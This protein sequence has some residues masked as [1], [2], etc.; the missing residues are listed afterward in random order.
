MLPRSSLIAAGP[1]PNF[2]GGTGRREPPP[3]LA[4][5]LSPKL[6]P[7]EY[8]RRN[9]TRRHRVVT[10]QGGAY[11]RGMASSRG[12]GRRGTSRLADMS[13]PADQRCARKTTRTSR[14]PV[15]AQMDHGSSPAGRRRRRDGERKMRQAR[16][17]PR[18][19]FPP[20]PRPGPGL[21]APGILG[22]DVRGTPLAGSPPDQPPARAPRAF[23]ERPG[24]HGPADLA[25]APARAV[26]DAGVQPQRRA[27]GGGQPEGGQDQAGDAPGGEGEQ[28]DPG[29]D[30]GEPRP[31]HRYPASRSLNISASAGRSWARCRSQFPS[32]AAAVSAS[33]SGPARNFRCRSPCRSTSTTRGTGTSAAPCGGALPTAAGSAEVTGAASGHVS[34]T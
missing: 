33:P 5:M 25:G 16:R 31:A 10:R 1:T 18:R 7:L 20:R 8:M 34:S 19:P 4:P 22:A 2:H 17:L 24:E 11:S 30:P 29:Q 23:P 15:P 9:L 32:S 28:Q 12:Y 13:L 3:M 21:P 14:K 6:F 26:A 27:V